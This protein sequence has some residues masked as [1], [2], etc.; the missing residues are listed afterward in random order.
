MRNNPSSVFPKKAKNF[1]PH[2]ARID[3]LR[4]V[5]I[6]FELLVQCQHKVVSLEKY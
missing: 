4:N 5:V 3:A 6:D 1:Q 2:S